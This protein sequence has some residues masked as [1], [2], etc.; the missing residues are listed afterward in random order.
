M[1]LN[2]VNLVSLKRSKPRFWLLY[3]TDFA[4]SQIRLVIQLLDTHNSYAKY[5]TSEGF[6]WREEIWRSDDTKINS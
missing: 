1:Q 2:P 4:I 5:L 3:Q 6:F